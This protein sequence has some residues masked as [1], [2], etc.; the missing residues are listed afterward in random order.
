MLPAPPS[1]REAALLAKAGETGVPAGTSRRRS[2]ICYTI[3]GTATAAGVVLPAL[4]E[5]LGTLP[6]TAPMVGLL[7][8]VTAALVFEWLHGTVR[9]VSHGPE[10]RLITASTLMGARTVDITALDR[11][12]RLCIPTRQTSWTVMWVTD[13]QGT[14]LW[15][16]DNYQREREVIERIAA[17]LRAPD[18]ARPADRTGTAAARV[19]RSAAVRLGLV[20]SSRGRRAARACV[21][22]LLGTTAVPAAGI[23]G[24][25]ATWSLATA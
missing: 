16:D 12:R 24:L 17:L 10:L 4:L 14:S 6:S 23:L 18:P 2:R 13:S 22:F 21:N 9:T 1:K 5:R 25:L 19:S 11:I 20:T 8:G 3:L 7:T 15:L